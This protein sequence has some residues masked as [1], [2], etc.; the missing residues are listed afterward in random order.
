MA[1]GTT[2]LGIGALT[3]EKRRSFLADL[4]IRL[5]REKPLGTVG[6]VIVLLLL[7]AGIF[8]NW[9]APYGYNEVWVGPKLGPTTVHFW[10][11]TDNLGRDQ[12]SR[13]IYGARISMFVGL[14]VSAIGVI[15]NAI[16]G[17]VSGFLGGATDLIIQRFVD[18]WMC[19]PGIFII[20]T[21]MAILGP[22]VPQM[23]IVL[24]VLY[25]IT[26]SRTIRSAVIAVK[27]NVYV[28]AAKAIG[29]PTWR[30]LIRHLL[31]N[32]MAPLIIIFTVSI[33]GAI[34]TESS[35][36]FLG[37][38][39]P[40]PIPSWGG[41]LSQ[42]RLDMFQA[43]WLAVWPGLALAIVVY[44]INMFGDALRDLLDP[45]LRGGLGRYSGR[46]LSKQLSRR[47]PVDK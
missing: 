47:K 40:P 17:L 1:E 2:E 39:I 9:L 45:R 21:V 32:I 29:C 37:Y 3:K 4:F 30:I 5:V 44:G 46:R 11:G 28:E 20:L 10:L 33:G 12:L 8:A 31:P 26:G 19:F 24:G 16:I 34:L 43:P 6:A 14:G 15:L 23:I 18:A 7:L 27:E 35:V 36:S 22:G 42:G 25:G 41:M 13:V 38:G